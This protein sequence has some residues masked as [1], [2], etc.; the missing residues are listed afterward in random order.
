MLRIAKKTKKVNTGA[1]V[2]IKNVECRNVNGEDIIRGTFI[3]NFSGLTFVFD[4]YYFSI[5]L[6]S[7]QFKRINL[8]KLNNSKGK[9]ILFDSFAAQ[10]LIHVLT[11][12]FIKNEMNIVCFE[13]FQIN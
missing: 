7:I 8:C 13:L 4:T 1:E 11:A 5:E 3:A 6:G 9:N 10:I 2:E 12:L